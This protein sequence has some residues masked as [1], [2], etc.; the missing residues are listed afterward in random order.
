MSARALEG[1]RVLDLTRL[2][3]GPYCTLVLS[4]LGATVDK[5]EEPGT[6]DYLRHMPPLADG[7]SGMFRALNRDKRSIAIDLKKKPDG[8]ALLLEIVRRY[9]VVVEGFRPGVLDRLGVGPAAMRAAHPGLIVCSITGFGQTGPLAQRAGHDIGYLARA[10]VLGLQGPATGVPQV[11][12]IQLADIAGGGMWAV[13]AI[14]SAL[15]ERQRTGTGKHVDVAM[16]DGAH[17]FLTAA[18]GSFFADGKPPARGGEHLTGGIAP[19]RV[20]AT[21]DGGHIAVGAL[22]P[23]FWTNLCT[24][25]GLPLEFGALVPGDHQPAL[26]EQLAAIFATKT[27]DEWSAILSASDTCAEPVLTLPETLDDPHLRARGRVDDHAVR[28]PGVP[29][30]SSPRP[31]PGI[32]EHTDEILREHGIDEGRI[33][34]LRTA[35][36]VA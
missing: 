4:D 7:V 33:A 34:T 12:G 20:Y 8:P 27:K 18:L 26:Q 25:I 24:A 28:T 17:A 31:A 2:L 5:V 19:Y 1:V 35:G 13:V 6:G 29:A 16:V 3:P 22:E 11:L 30:T 9:D 14:L 10:G 32:G 36:V 23:K 21:K 15:L